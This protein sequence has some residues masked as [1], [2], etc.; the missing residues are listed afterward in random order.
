[1][2]RPRKGIISTRAIPG[3]RVT[4]AIPKIEDPDP[5]LIP[6]EEAPTEEEPARTVNHV[7]CFDVLLEQ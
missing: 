7:F 2:K 4:F 5:H 1:M 6:N 3:D